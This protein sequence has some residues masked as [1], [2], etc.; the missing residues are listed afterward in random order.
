MMG[1]AGLRV[2]VCGEGEN[3]QDGNSACEKG[4]ERSVH[5]QEFSNDEVAESVA[6]AGVKSKSTGGREYFAAMIYLMG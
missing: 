6:E 3:E 1:G 5:D 2:Q 4:F